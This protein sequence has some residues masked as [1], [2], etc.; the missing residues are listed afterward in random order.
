M[1]W[2][3]EKET[4]RRMRRHLR[5]LVVVGILLSEYLA[6]TL[7]FEV[8]PYARGVKT[9]IVAPIFLIVLSVSVRGLLRH[10]GW[11]CVSSVARNCVRLS[12][13]SAVP[14][15]HTW[16]ASFRVR[17]PMPWDATVFKGNIIDRK[18]IKGN[19]A[20][21]DKYELEGF[22]IS[23]YQAE[24]IGVRLQC[25]PHDGMCDSV[26]HFVLALEY[27]IGGGRERRDLYSCLITI[28][29]TKNAESDRT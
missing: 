17:N 22:T 4:R 2:F 25:G 8:L 15:I 26:M 14:E 13:S 19:S 28:R 29:G 11:L 9:A 20:V 12:A 10:M 23:K 27:S 21:L 5:I 16:Q 3:K 1:L 7:L 18:V 24:T 6:A